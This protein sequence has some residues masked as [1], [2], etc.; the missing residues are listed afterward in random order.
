[1]FREP[2]LFF[3]VSVGSD[4]NGAHVL[5]LFCPVRLFQVKIEF[6]DKPEIY[7]EFLDIMKN[8]KV[9]DLPDLRWGRLFC[10]GCG[11]PSG[12]WTR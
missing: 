12:S 3:F 6:G 5:P 10:S 2:R 1:M 7:N 11:E 9:R 4:K 8:F